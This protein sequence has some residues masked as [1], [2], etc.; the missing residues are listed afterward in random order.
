MS[1]LMN[2][3][4]KHGACQS[5]KN[6]LNDHKIRTIGAAWKQCD[7][8]DWMLWFW[9]RTGRLSSQTACKIAAVC[10]RRVLPVFQQKYPDDNRP[11]LA[12]EAAEKYAENPT[13]ENAHAAH[14]AAHAAAAYAAAYTA[15]AASAAYAAAYAAHAAAHA[16]AAY[17]AAYAASAASAAYAA[18]Y[19]ASAAA[20]AYAAGAATCAERKWQADYL[21]SLWPTWGD[22]K[23]EDI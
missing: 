1:K 10:A 18:A 13:A 16:A 6:W 4:Q 15:S 21:R 7:R 22:T 14:A 9:A 19:A 17:A 3:L 5:A 11:R 8:G 2:L 23:R 12:I 20:A